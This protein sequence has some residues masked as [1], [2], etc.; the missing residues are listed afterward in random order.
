[1]IHF[2]AYSLVDI[3]HTQEYKSNK[4]NKHTFLQQQNLNTL[5]QTIGLRSQPLEPKVTVFMAQDVADYGFGKRYSGLHTVWNLDFSIEHS[6]VFANNNDSLY[7]L[8]TDCDGVAI[9]CKLEETAEINTK[10]FETLNNKNLYFKFNQ[11]NNQTGVNIF[12]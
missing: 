9:Y 1:M 8:N 6:N 4:P 10:A 5:I 7:Y 3:S 12:T 11:T 2:S